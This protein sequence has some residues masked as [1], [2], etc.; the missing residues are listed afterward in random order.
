MESFIATAIVGIVLIPIILIVPIC[1]FE[2]W[3]H[4]NFG[5]ENDD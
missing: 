5:E 1:L 3:W 2:L 4:K